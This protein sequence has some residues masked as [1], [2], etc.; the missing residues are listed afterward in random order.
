MK[1]SPAI[2]LIEFSSI[3]AGIRAG[4]AM[5]KKAPIALLKTG[6]VSR[7]HYLVLIGGSVASVE[8]SY[9]EG[10]VYGQDC[11]IDKVL[12]PDIH[13]QV[14]DAITG[15]RQKIQQESFGI[16]ETA[17]VAAI[18]QA[19]DAAIKGALINIIEIRLADALGGKGLVLM[20]GK[21]EDI[22]IAIDIGLNAISSKALW[23][24][25]AIIPSI[26]KELANEING[27]TRFSN[28]EIRKLRGE[29]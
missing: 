23:R 12:L 4:D 22:E 9:Y 10:V 6:T 19:A 8:E 1:T 26:N 3:A 5:V 24:N 13:T 29:I 28:A 20:N 14:Y 27:T 16:I 21:V 18:I 17:S 25:S 11:V 7:G 2:A 15:E